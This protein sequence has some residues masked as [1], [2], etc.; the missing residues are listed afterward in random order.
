METTQRRSRTGCYTC[1]QRHLKCDEEKPICW[2]CRI[3][4]RN[5]LRPNNSEAQPAR[6]RRTA[7]YGKTFQ[8]ASP[9]TNCPAQLPIPNDM[10][11]NDDPSPMVAA[12][13]QSVSSLPDL[14]VIGIPTTPSTVIPSATVSTPLAEGT[15]SPGGA[16]LATSAPFDVQTLQ[17]IQLYLDH[18]D[19][20]AASPTTHGSV[21]A[22]TVSTEEETLLQHYVRR[23]AKWVRFS[24]ADRHFTITVPHLARR[25]PILLKAVS[26][27]AARH[28]CCLGSW[29]SAIAEDYHKQCI[30]LL[31]PAL[32]DPNAATDDT[33]L[34]ALVMLRLYEHLNV[35][36][37]G[38]DYE[39][40]LRGV[41]AM[42]TSTI[43]NP[44]TASGSGL[45]WAAFW[46]FF[47]QS[48]Y[49][50]CV[51]RQPLKFDI[52][53]SNIEVRLSSPAAGVMPT[54]EEESEWCHW[55]TWIL[56]QVAD[57]CFGTRSLELTPTEEKES[58]NGLVQAVDMWEANKPKSF[59]PVAC[60]DREPEQGR[61]FPE[62][63][64]GSEWHAMAAAQ[65]LA[66]R[67][68][69]DVHHPQT[70]KITIGEFGFLR[71][72]QQ[73]ERKVLLHAR[74]LCGICLTDPTNVSA[75]FTMC[76][77][78]FTF[79]SF[80][81]IDEERRLLVRVL[82]TVERDEGWPT[83]W[84]VNALKVDWDVDWVDE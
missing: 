62:I 73:L 35:S 79:S 43:R 20:K 21:P 65:S 32:G 15:A 10:R 3:G 4:G 82:R 29:D 61:W 33:L 51:Y 24:D 25:S 5:C 49:P 12:P 78:I 70:R 50:A 83:T 55:I 36:D 80:I 52:S 34:A 2:R 28:L 74:S 14:G 19:I 63:W 22:F 13:A 45:K 60:N 68:L 8:R 81:N 9:D 84:I 58:W 1:R 11:G 40:H 59:L 67:I 17:G 30:G 16:D 44:W 77:A 31:I 39:H 66:A 42:V 6:P 64:F 48:I 41:S 18:S 71:A 69:L 53:G 46:C 75:I 72:R 27:L 7:I 38:Q 56:G 26:A 23:L 47:R 76:H 57:F 54:V 37:S